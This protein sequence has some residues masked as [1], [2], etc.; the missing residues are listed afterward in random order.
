MDH[1]PICDVAVRPENLL[2]HL[3][4]IHPR[5]PDT[6]KLVERLKAEPGRIAAR[7]PSRPLR[8]SRLQVIIVVL[9]ILLGLVAYVVVNVSRPSPL[10]CISGNGLAYHWHTKLVILSGG[11]Q[12]TIPGSI[13]I[14]FTCMEVLHTHDSDGVIHIEPDTQQQARVYTVGDFFAVWQ[15]PFGNPTRMTLNGT[16]VTPSPTVGLYNTPEQIVLEYASFTP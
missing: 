13:G 1:C 2:R 15:K 4:D 14:S 7:T 5:H 3:N 10:P 11:T 16:A 12:V 6:P 8:V 9:V